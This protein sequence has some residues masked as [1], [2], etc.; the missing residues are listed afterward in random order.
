MQRGIWCLPVFLFVCSWYGPS[1]TARPASKPQIFSR[2]ASMFNLLT[3]S[4]I[5]TFRRLLRLTF[6]VLDELVVS[7]TSAL[8]STLSLLTTDT[9]FTA[10]SRNLRQKFDQSLHLLSGSSIASRPG[11]KGPSVVDCSKRLKW[12]GCF[13][14]RFSRTART[15]NS[16]AT[17]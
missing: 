5:L 14:K 1:I 16:E 3:S 10:S 12:R 7:A 8:L 17:S 11:F 9:T 6:I 4:S 2:G 13:F 15:S